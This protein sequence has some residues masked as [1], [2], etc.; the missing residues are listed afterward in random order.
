[1]RVLVS[2]ASLLIELAKWSLLEALF[3]LPFEFAIP[4]ALYEDELIDLGELD[5]EQLKVL[6]LRV[7]SLDGEGMVQAVT[8]QTAQPKH[9]LHDRPSFKPCRMIYRV[10]G[11]RVVICLIVDGRGEMKSLLARGLPGA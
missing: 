4:D 9:T 3:E 11:D 6:G 7:E 10:L 2:D 5:R 1:M 8:Y